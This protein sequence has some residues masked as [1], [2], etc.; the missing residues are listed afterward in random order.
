MLVF[1]V[2]AVRRTHDRRSRWLLGGYV[3]VIVVGAIAWAGTDMALVRFMTA[4]SDSPGRFVAWRDAWQIAS[5]FPWVG[6]G[7]GTFGKA[8]LVYQTA[9]RPWM[10]AQ[11]HND[12]LQLLAEGGL[13]V[14]LPALVAASLVL[15][16]I[17]HRLA[18]AADPPL[19]RW[20]RAGA[21][22]GLAGIAAQSAVEFSLQM[23]GNTVLF[24]LLLALA[25]HR[26]RSE[27]RS[28]AAVRVRRVVTHGH[29][30]RV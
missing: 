13:L 23:P 5:D 27:S 2:F 25:M 7:L 12:Y 26:P 3:L 28:S 9:S 8:M 22:A 30:H 29:A 14:V 21:V 15:V 10:Y 18:Q 24:V 4:R 1:G 11:A 17:R 16:A 20:I 19:T 6:T